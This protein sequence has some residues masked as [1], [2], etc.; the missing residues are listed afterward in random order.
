MAAFVREIRFEPDDPRRAEVR[1]AH[2]AHLRELFERGDLITSGPWAA[3]DGAILVYN[4]ADE[5]RALELVHA[6]P[7]FSEGVV[8]EVSLRQWN[9]V[10]PPPD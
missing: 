2:V 5:N 3:G 6:D 7:F 10:F 4:A 8:T 1:A 9:R